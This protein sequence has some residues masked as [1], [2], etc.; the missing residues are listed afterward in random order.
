M[1][2]NQRIE[3]LL[4][5]MTV[6]E[7]I[8]QTSQR[9]TSSM[10]KELPASLMEA[11]RKGRVGSAINITNRDLKDQ[12]QRIAVEES[13]NGIPILYGR[14]VIHGYKTIFPI[15][16]GQ[17]ASWNP[18]MVK[19]GSR[20][21]AAEA[22][23]NGIKW[24]FAPMIDISRDPRWGRIAESA[25][26]DT[27]LT[28]V[29]ARAYVQ[30]FQGDDLANPASLLACAK[31]F[32]AYGA[33]E[34]GRDY[35]TSMVPE[36][37]LRE[38]YLPPFKA[39]V[40]AGVATFMTSFNDINGVPAT[41]NR[42]LL[43]DVLR[44]EWGFEGFVVSDWNS[45]IEMIDHGYCRDHRE[46]ALKAANAGLDMEMTSTAYEEN[47]K[48]LIDKGIVTEA[49]LDGMVRNIL[50][51]KFR[52]GLFDNPYVDRTRD[53]V[54]LSES[55]LAA[56]KEA[57]IQSMVLLKNERS[58][59]PLAPTAK[60]ALVGPLANAPHEQLGTW[61][62]DG[63]KE[64]S[65][66]PW[67]ALKKAYGENL[68]FTPG[69][70]YSRDRSEAG[71][72]PAISQANKSDLILFVGGE[73]SILSGEAH[74]RAD[75]SLPGAQEQ[76]IIELSKTGKPI[77]LVIF[78]GRPIS[79]E[80]IKDKLAALVMGWH[81]G[82]MAGPALTELLLGKSN[83]SGRLPVT[84]PKTSGQAP[85]YYNHT[86]TGRPASPKTYVPLDE[87]PIEAWQSSLGNTSHYM[88]LGFSP[89]YPFGYG[90]SY[91]DFEYSDL[92][93]STSTIGRNGSLQVSATVK[94]TG[95]EDGTEVVQLYIRDLV[96][97]RARP[98]R[99]LKGFECI[100][101]RAGESRAVTF[102]ISASDLAYYNQEMKLVTDAGDFNVW[103][104][105]N[106][107]SGLMGKFTVMG[108]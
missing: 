95:P 68:L 75:I 105:S 52:A 27:Y 2:F 69:L 74:S 24:T 58:I 91:T 42:W 23:T 55:H 37:L 72:S 48:D 39:A 40:D 19:E 49:Q 70:S 62:F 38:V 15:P 3:E 12:L 45:V 64:S 89:Q 80:R 22:T 53:H 82:T 107:E 7:K 11:V 28:S 25:G 10:V 77:V 26:E 63:N 100:E 17:A 108:E 78:A 31:H 66:T 50:S 104:A 86:N 96:A 93:L 44:K 20:I 87:I 84:W 56:A 83:F 76:L 29:M 41:G 36:H 4:S 59:L 9:G 103:I 94:N 61:I 8:G 18:E 90:L 1:N 33:V 67:G 92:R 97:D 99:E 60:I 46:A 101:L 51:I 98:I 14:D 54:V 5:K 73:E 13:A 102:T 65:V 35:N 81:P 47:M 43:T 32:A 6:E 79:I 88:D 34:G 85:I 57:A 71:F 30:G 21:A 106:A 16:I